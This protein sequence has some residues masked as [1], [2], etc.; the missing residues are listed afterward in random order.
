MSAEPNESRPVPGVQSA[1]PLGANVPARAVARQ[2]VDELLVKLSSPETGEKT[3]SAIAT[4][5]AKAEQK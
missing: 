2:M 5:L 3:R 1:P 4:L